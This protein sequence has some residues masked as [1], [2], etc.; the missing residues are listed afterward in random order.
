MKAQ[1]RFYSQPKLTSLDDKII[2]PGVLLSS[3][4]KRLGWLM[5]FTIEEHVNENECVGDLQ[6]MTTPNEKYF[7]KGTKFLAIDDPRTFNFKKLKKNKIVAEGK[8]LGNKKKKSSH[9]HQGTFN[10]IKGG[11][12]KYRSGWEEKFMM[13]LDS[14]PDVISWSYE[15]VCIEYVS[16]KKT[17]K[18]RRYYPDFLVI[19]KNNTELIE[20]K[21]SKKLK[22]ATV[23]KKVEAAKN[24]CSSR[25]I[26]Y[27]VLTE[28]ELKNFEII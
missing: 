17:G 5:S 11:E 22:Q 7:S 15:K 10:S 24:W 12:C 16:N 20:I 27:K 14:N 23:I 25:N 19:Y 8:I 26:T 2:F 13:Y 1:I 6:W 4:C 9:Y 28:I 18:I 21:P 3:T